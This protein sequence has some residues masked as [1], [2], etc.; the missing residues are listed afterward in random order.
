MYISEIK[1]KNFRKFNN[2]NFF[3]KKGLNV[4]VG[5][6][7]CGKTT[8]IDAIRFILDT[9][10]FVKIEDTDFNDKEKELQITLKFEDL[11]DEEQTA[12]LEFLTF[13]KVE[14]E[15]K[16]FLYLSLISKLDRSYRLLRRIKAGKDAENEMDIEVR[17]LIYMAYFKP[18]RDAET[19]LSPG[20]YSRLSKI[21]QQV[22]TEG[23]ENDIIKIKEALD[24]FHHEVKE[25]NV[26]KNNND[27]ISNYLK[28]M[29]L[30]PEKDNIK[31][32]IELASDGDE[33]EV[34]KKITE[35]LGLDFKNAPKQ[36]LG[37]YNLLYMA[38][39]LILLKHGEISS[40]LL[41]EEPEAHL[42]PQLQYNLLR[43]INDELNIDNK[44]TQIFL[45]THSPNLSSK[46]NVEDI[47]LFYG[48][49][50]Y[51]LKKEFTKA[52]ED[53][54]IFLSK[55][56]DVTKANLFYSRGLIF[57]EG[58]S[59]E[60]LIPAFA[61]AMGYDLEEYGVSVINLNNTGF[62]RFTN[63]FIQK[64]EAEN[65]KC[66]IP[67]KISCIRDLD[68]FHNGTKE[69]VTNKEGKKEIKKIKI[70]PYSKE[71]IEGYEKFIDKRYKELKKG[72]ETEDN[73]IKVFI[74]DYRTLEVDL[75]NYC[76]KPILKILK[77]MH[78][79]AEIYQT[80]ELN[81]TDIPKIYHKI[82]SNKDK[83]ELAYKLSLK[84]LKYLK[85]PEI[86]EKIKGKIPPYIKNAIKHVIGK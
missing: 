77:E 22:E 11:T 17:N 37:Y 15:N 46:V 63:F 43:F 40:F 32:E 34:F 51:S 67:I 71:D 7:N 24:K 64:D 59:E 78:S 10:Y 14:N 23:K 47:I 2:E 30:Y 55:F 41:I 65:L 5:E 73:Y 52:S 57:V 53:D 18:L 25:Q 6:N 48:N 80:G 9:N 29:L 76:F 26:I 42:H 13:E 81:N 79:N 35:K 54:Y 31:T 69:T 12:F 27:D 75:L 85:N 83:S 49:K 39:E 19:E 68:Y 36:G 82:V 33:N 3:F 28:K 1:I 8:I 60:I 21:L 72:I 56:L 38:V 20:R 4:L 74:S 84:I 50:L 16:I 86:K 45:S 70:I 61:K 58:F 44:K 62:K 66:R